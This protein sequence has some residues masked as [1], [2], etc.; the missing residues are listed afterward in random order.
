MRFAPAPSISPAPR[1]CWA[2]LAVVV[3]LACGPSC[4]TAQETEKYGNW[5][6]KCEE[7]RGKVQGGCFIF[8]NLVLREGGQRV[9]Q[10]AVGYVAA[11]DAP[12]ALLSLPLGISLPPGVSIRIGDAQPTRVIVE[13]CEPNGCRAGL[14]LDD[15]LLTQLRHGTQ[16]TVTFHDA[17]R[18]PIEVP[19]SLDGF[20]AGLD[21]LKAK[22]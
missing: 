14:K 2:L 11:T 20:E 7:S 13:R 16:L 21:A 1:A 18:R 3:G 15:A 22:S 9:L 10:F 19:L 17:E 4:V 5:T 6:A 12:I 8:Q